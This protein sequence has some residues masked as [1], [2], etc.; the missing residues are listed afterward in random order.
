MKLDYDITNK[1]LP[2]E[3]S[4]IVDVVMWPRFGN[5]GIS[6][7]EVIIISILKEFVIK[8]PS[9]IGLMMNLLMDFSLS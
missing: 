3:S 8:T 1:T 4:Y 5:S 7:R 6:I 2:R 9:W